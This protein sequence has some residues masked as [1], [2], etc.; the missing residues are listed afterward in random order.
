MNTTLSTILLATFGIFM[1][2][3]SCFGQ[4][5][6]FQDLSVIQKYDH[7]SSSDEIVEMD[8]DYL[9]WLEAQVRAPVLDGPQGP[10]PFLPGT[11]AE[12]DWRVQGP[13]VHGAIVV[14]S[15]ADLPGEHKDSWAGISNGFIW[16]TTAESSVRNFALD[17]VV[18]GLIDIE[19]YISKGG[20]FMD[21]AVLM[22]YRQEGGHESG[23]EVG[24]YPWS[25]EELVILI[26]PT[27]DPEIDPLTGLLIAPWDKDDDGIL[28]QEKALPTDDDRSDHPLDR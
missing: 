9:Q 5:A 13:V 17:A 11:H 10:G 23:K 18:H 4:D 27:D 25:E 12:N 16:I 3:L 20:N 6:R 8:E 7:G 21:E 24:H 14:G 19:D 15:P 22:A 26:L 2:S 1:F 28:D